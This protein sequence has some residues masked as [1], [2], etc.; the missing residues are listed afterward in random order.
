MKRP[1]TTTVNAVRTLFG[2][3]EGARVL[4][5]HRGSASLILEEARVA[6]GRGWDLIR[7]VRDL[8]YQ[9]L[10]E[11]PEDVVLDA[12]ARVADFAKQRFAG[13]SY[14]V[15]CAAWL[16]AQNRLIAF[17]ELFAGT[18]TQTSVY[19]RRVCIRALEL[20]ASAV[21]LLHDHPSKIPTPSRADQV[22]TRELSTALKLLDVQVLDHIIVGGDNHFSFAEHGML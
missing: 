11:T 5:A 20:R 18:D 13:L 9:A 21:I 6:Y 17:E 4:K 16:N 1:T 15:F 19:P 7:A 22:L 14:E 2:V 10:L 12:P 3:R 8:T